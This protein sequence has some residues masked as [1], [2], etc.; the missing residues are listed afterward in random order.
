MSVFRESATRPFQDSVTYLPGNSAAFHCLASNPRQM[1]SHCLVPF[2][3]MS[4][5]EDPN[6]EV[7]DNGQSRPGRP[8][9][10]LPLSSARLNTRRTCK[11]CKSPWPL[12]PQKHTPHCPRPVGRQTKKKNVQLSSGSDIPEK[13]HC[14]LLP[15]R[16]RLIDPTVRFLPVYGPRLGIRLV[17]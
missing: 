16:A 14:D 11:R 2:Q 8:R 7:P 5:H 3:A 13:L 10:L 15:E 1:T 9:C 4:A 12:L 17:P 6:R